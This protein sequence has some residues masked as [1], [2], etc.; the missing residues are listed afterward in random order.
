MENRHSAEKRDRE[1]KTF[2]RDFPERGFQGVAR[3]ENIP[4]PR[5]ATIANTLAWRDLCRLMPCRCVLALMLSLWCRARLLSQRPSRFVLLLL[6]LLLFF[7]GSCAGQNTV[8][9]FLAMSSS[10]FF[11]FSQGLLRVPTLS[12]SPALRLSVS[13][14]DP[15]LSLA[16]TFSVPRSF[17]LT[18]N[19]KS[20][21][22][23]PE[24]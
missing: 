2:I 5:Q 3:A 15:C 21:I 14:S 16:S 18:R 9:D 23:N 8:D 24:P 19:P 11:F 13:L 4:P 12:V 20:E 22:L 1:R 10:I 17:S 6:L 7:C